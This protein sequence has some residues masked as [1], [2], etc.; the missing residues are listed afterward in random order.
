MAGLEHLTH[1]ALA[2][3]LQQDVGTQEEFPGPAARHLVDLVGREPTALQQGAGQ[4]VQ[5]DRVAVLGRQLIELIRGKQRAFAEG[6]D[7]LP[8]RVA[9]RRGPSAPDGR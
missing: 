8:D 3:W 6:L 4:G 5:V 2:E 7:E 9:I 1:A